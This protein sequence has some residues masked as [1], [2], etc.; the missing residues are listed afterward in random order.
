[1][2]GWPIKRANLTN[3]N[4]KNLR[5]RDQTAKVLDRITLAHKLN[6][7]DAVLLIIGGEVSRGSHASAPRWL[8]G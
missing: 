8:N 3:L 4:F 5:K 6:D 2:N 1:M 7:L